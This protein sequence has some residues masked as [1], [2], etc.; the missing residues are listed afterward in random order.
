MAAAVDPLACQQRQ[1]GGSPA[2]SV[3]G[4]LKAATLPL[5][6][7]SMP[8]PAAV[9]PLQLVS[10]GVAGSTGLHVASC[11]RRP[12]LLQLSVWCGDD[13]EGAASCAVRCTCLHLRQE[14]DVRAW[15]Q[16]CQR[17]GSKINACVDYL[18]VWMT[19]HVSER[20]YQ[21]SAEG[22]ARCVHPQWQFQPSGTQGSADDGL[23]CRHDSLPQ[24]QPS[25]SHCSVTNW[26]HTNCQGATWKMRHT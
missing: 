23:G 2:E 17:L 5:F 18:P 14:S 20:A 15:P 6:E 19:R 16:Q 11:M 1:I 4:S 9:L 24:L 25:V 22:Q 10:G 8:E 13:N 7:P 21:C 3:Q 12:P 26:H